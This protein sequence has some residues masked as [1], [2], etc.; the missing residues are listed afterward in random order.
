M[1]MIRIGIGFDIHRLEAGRKLVLGGVEIPHP[2]GL[3]GHSDA[4]VLLHALADALLGAASLGDIG[5]HFPPDDPRYSGADS[6]AL[7]GRVVELLQEKGWRVVN[8]DSVIMAEQPRLGPHI[9]AMREKISGLLRLAPE[10]VSVKATTCEGLGLVG[11]EE[12]IA[13]QAVVLIEADRE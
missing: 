4:D 10:A 6:G 11:R 13:A 3:L 12:G 1:P 8:L 5:L 7:L 2:T 9:P